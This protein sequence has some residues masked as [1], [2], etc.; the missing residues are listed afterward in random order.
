MRLWKDIAD[1][2]DEFI[3]TIIREERLNCDKLDHEIKEGHFYVFMQWLFWCF[4]KLEERFNLRY[5]RILG[6]L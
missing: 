3:V 5:R 6:K 1:Q 2:F 4:E